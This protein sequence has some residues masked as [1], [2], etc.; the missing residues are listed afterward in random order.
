MTTVPGFVSTVPPKSV[1]EAV[2]QQTHDRL[3]TIAKAALERYIRSFL[4]TTGPYR[5]AIEAVGKGSLQYI[6][7]R[8]LD[9]TQDVTRRT[10]QLARMFNEIRQRVPAILIVD[11]G[12]Q[13]IPSGLFSGLVNSTLIDGKWQGW[14]N[15]QFRIPLSILIVTADQDS[16]DQLM[17]LVELQLNNLRQLAGGSALHGLKPGENWEVRLPLEIGLSGSAGQNITED[18]KDQ[19]WVATIELTVDAEDTFAIE[20]PFDTQFAVG[21]FDEDVVRG[22]VLNAP[23]LSATLPPV[24][25]APDTMQLGI[26]TTVSFRRLRLTHRIVIDQPQ[27]ATID[28]ESRTVMPRRPGSFNLI[29][30]DVGERQTSRRALAP[31]IAAQKLIT[32]TL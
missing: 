22:A 7:D 2:S 16:T 14:F 21:T 27:V 31:T 6:T 23:N 26:A 3:K 30:M 13:S 8:S 25:E 10:T 12:T 32:V 5:S 18:Q 19:L 1:V 4:D 24:I 28:V 29:V 9:A 17:E 15:K 11:A 20:M